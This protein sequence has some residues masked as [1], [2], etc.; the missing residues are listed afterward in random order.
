MSLPQKFLIESSH[1]GFWLLPEAG[2]Y[3]KLVIHESYHFGDNIVE[4]RG[5]GGRW[6]PVLALLANRRVIEKH[7]PSTAALFGSLEEKDL[8]EESILARLQARV[9]SELN[10][11]F[12][13]QRGTDGWF[14]GDQF[15]KT[16]LAEVIN[17]NSSDPED[18][19]FAAVEKVLTVSSSGLT[20][21]TETIRDFLGQ[22]IGLRNILRSQEGV[23]L[24]K[25]SKVIVKGKDEVSSLS[26]SEVEDLLIRFSAQA[27][28][29]LTSGNLDIQQLVLGATVLVLRAAISYG[30]EVNKQEYHPI[31]ASCLKESVL[32]EARLKELIDLTISNGFYKYGGLKRVSG[33][34][35]IDPSVPGRAANSR[36]V[37]V[38][39][40]KWAV[41]ADGLQILNFVCRS[42]PDRNTTGL[43]QTGYIKVVN[44]GGML[45][46]A[47]AAVLP[48]FSYGEPDVHVM[49]SCPDFKYRFHWVLAQAGASPTPTGTGDEATNKPPVK[50][51]PSNRPS[52]CKHL[53]ACGSIV[54]FS[55]K[56]FKD[57]KKKQKEGPVVPVAPNEDPVVEPGAVV[58][59]QEAA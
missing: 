11:G 13:L 56:E 29:K 2:D 42:R 43:R 31:V 16:E 21:K 51:N 6:L 49:C 44:R 12:W 55:S 54:N 20:T 35:V 39:V 4:V 28:E 5:A 30:F 45:R 3:G 26:R 9:T 33:T 22:N 23:P 38:S 47:A 14:C 59:P 25:L 7:F 50:T 18:T 41:G 57:S 17:A 10:A 32:N 46:R 1:L 27:V 19:N 8:L 58:T 52:L 15:V 36:F 34:W 24:E 40:P 37:V 53:M 48:R